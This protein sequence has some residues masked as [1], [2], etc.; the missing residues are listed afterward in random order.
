M[1]RCR[2][3][4]NDFCVRRACIVCASCP[5]HVFFCKVHRCGSLDRSQK[6]KFL[7]KSIPE[8]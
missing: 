4:H 2:D 3:E 5:L 1:G 7:I 6:K 8:A